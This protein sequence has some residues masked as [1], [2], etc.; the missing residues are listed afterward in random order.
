MIYPE[1]WLATTIK[2][3]DMCKVCGHAGA[4]SRALPIEHQR[5]LPLA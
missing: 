3:L 1:E 4:C 5:A 2:D